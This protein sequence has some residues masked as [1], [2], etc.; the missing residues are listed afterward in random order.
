M[1]ADKD[2]LRSHLRM[3]R[4]R[5]HH[6][7]GGKAA[8][9]VQDHV[10]RHLE[11]S[12]DRIV[13]GYWPIGSEMDPRPL[14]MTL[15]DR[16]E[17]LALPVVTA[18]EAPLAFRSFTFAD[19]L[20]PGLC[21]TQEPLPGQPF[22][23]PTLLLVPLLGFDKRG[24]RLGQGGGY[25]DRTLADLRANGAIQAIG[26]AYAVQ[27]IDKLPDEAHDQKLDAIVTEEG[28]IKP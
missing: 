3:D 12:E 23:R 20:Q 21:S 15:Q 25:Y 22:V 28:F 10:L 14:M 27:Q 16:G 26:L 17:H 2:S 13:A 7:W 11:K 5:A 8:L 1:T 19:D 9:Q 4:R 18:I 6:F 24:F